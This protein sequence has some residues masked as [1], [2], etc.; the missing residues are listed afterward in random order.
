MCKHVGLKETYAFG[1][2][3]N[4]DVGVEVYAIIGREGKKLVERI[5]ERQ[6]AKFYIA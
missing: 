3:M 1:A 6:W 2:V 4:S 5:G